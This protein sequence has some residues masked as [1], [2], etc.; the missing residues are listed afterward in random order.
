MPASLQGCAYADPFAIC[1][2]DCCPNDCCPDRA[3]MQ[4]FSTLAPTWTL[5]AVRS[6][7]E[8]HNVAVAPQQKQWEPELSVQ[9]CAWL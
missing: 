4:T 1:I 9:T 8:K 2:Q 5:S 7:Q 3:L 6:R